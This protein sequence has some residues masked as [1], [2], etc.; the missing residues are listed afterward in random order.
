MHASSITKSDNVSFRSIL[1]RST[2]ARSGYQPKAMEEV[3]PVTIVA[4]F[5]VKN[6]NNAET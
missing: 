5:N 3:F 4:L 2:N 6:Y 1:I